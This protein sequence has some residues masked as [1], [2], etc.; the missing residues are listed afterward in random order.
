MTIP[1][2]PRCSLAMLI[3]KIYLESISEKMYTALNYH[4]ATKLAQDGNLGDGNLVGQSAP[5][6]LLGELCIYIINHECLSSIVSIL[7]FRGI[8][9]ILLRLL[10]CFVIL[11]TW[12]DTQLTYM[13]WKSRHYINILV[14][15]LRTMYDFVKS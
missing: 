2:L 7:M 13:K 15:S 4:S 11:V 10:N 1:A 3:L 12:V 5:S 6:G 14:F 8:H 9:S